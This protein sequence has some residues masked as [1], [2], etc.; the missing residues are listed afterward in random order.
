MLRDEVLYLLRSDTEALNAFGVKSIGEATSH[1][2]EDVVSE[3][4]EFPALTSEECET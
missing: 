4:S 3:Y 2:P 1:V